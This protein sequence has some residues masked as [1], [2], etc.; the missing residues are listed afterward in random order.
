MA[1]L[2]SLVEDA[3]GF[4]KNRG[5]KVSVKDFKFLTLKSYDANGQVLDEFGNVIGGQNEYFDASTIKRILDEY[6]DYIQ[7]LIIGIIL[8]IFY[9]RFVSNSELVILGEGKKKR[10]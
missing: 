5:D 10:N 2:Q 1:N 6:K 9:R 4:D 8:F 7:Y 3:I